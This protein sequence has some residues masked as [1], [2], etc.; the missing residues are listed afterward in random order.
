M[1]G[2]SG[3]VG[4][5]VHQENVIGHRD[6]RLVRGFGGDLKVTLGPDGASRGV[7]KVRHGVIEEIGVANRRLTD[8]SRAD[9]R[10]LTSFG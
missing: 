8:S 7:L 9:R 6:R 10:F 1:P 3:S 2:S 5:W 4:V